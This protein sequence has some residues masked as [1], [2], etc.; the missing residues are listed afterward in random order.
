MWSYKVY[1]KVK[2]NKLCWVLKEALYTRVHT[3]WFYLHEVQE[4]AKLITGQK[5]KRTKVA[6]HEGGKWKSKLT[7]QGHERTFGCDGN[8][9]HPNRSMGHMGVCIYHNSQN[10]TLKICAFHSVP[11]TSKNV[12]VINSFIIY[13]LKCLVRKYTHV[14]NLLWNA[15]RKQ[16]GLMDG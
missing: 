3:A 2:V 8:I 14:C 9:S 6:S 11:F 12:K 1:N 15:S 5:K 7:E 16:N 10:D 4:Q 13:M